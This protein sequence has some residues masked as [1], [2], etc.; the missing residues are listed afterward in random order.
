MVLEM[1]TV[2]LLDTIFEFIAKELEKNLNTQIIISNNLLEM[3]QKRHT[4]LHIYFHTYMDNYEVDKWYTFH[5]ADKTSK[6]IS[7]LGVRKYDQ[8]NQQVT[9]FTYEGYNFSPNK[10]YRKGEYIYYE[11]KVEKVLQI[12]I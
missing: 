8:D 1:Q 4:S 9:R 11:H 2:N 10:P 5:K 3:I 7:K 6:T 12:C